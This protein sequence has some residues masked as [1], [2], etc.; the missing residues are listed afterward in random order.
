MPIIL[1]CDAV[2]KLREQ[3]S[4]PAWTQE[5]YQ[6][7]RSKYT[8]CCSCPGG[9]GTPGGCP[10]ARGG[11]PGGCLPARGVYPR[12]A[13]PAVG[14]P[15]VGAPL[16]GGVPQVG[17]PPAGGYPGWVLPCRGVPRAG[18]PL[19]D[20]VPPHHQLD[21]VP[22]TISWMG[23]PP[24]H[25]ELDG[26]P[27]PPPRVWTDT[28]TENITS[29]RTTYAVGKN[30]YNSCMSHRVQHWQISNL[31]AYGTV[32]NFD[33]FTTWDNDFLCLL[34]STKDSLHLQRLKREHREKNLQQAKSELT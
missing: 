33:W 3:E 5:A 8:L 23:Y 18:T 17:A 31:I 25:H 20:G 29:S 28:Q 12:Q 10:P 32:S 16:L 15:W 19:L 24:P 1:G 26:V 7:P 21:G 4:P 27:P 11:T 2:K 22:P 13:H 34:C 30:N 14:V 9:G 6:P